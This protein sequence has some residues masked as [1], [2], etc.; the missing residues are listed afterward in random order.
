M[1]LNKP[2]FW[3]FKKANLVAYLLMPL[4]IFVRINNFILSFKVKKKNLKIKSIC[5]GN[6]YLGGTGKTPLTIK[7]YEI[8]KKL[9]LNVVVGKKFY[10]SQL[11]ERILLKKY[12]NTII[13]FD[14]KKILEKAI[15]RNFDSI[16]FDDGL[17]EKKL[18]YDLQIV[19]F[20]TQNFVG[21]NFLIPSGPLREKL[22]SLKKYDCV[23]LKDNNLS[24]QKIIKSIKKV[25]KKIKFFYT[26]FKIVNLNKF[27][28]S[29]KYLIYSGIG[30]PDSFKK[31]LKNNKFNIIKE[32]IF[33]D[34]FKYQKADIKNIKSYAKKLNA[35][36][37]TTEKDYVKISKLDQK[38]INFLKVETKIK[39]EKSFIKF[40]KT[41]IYD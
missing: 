3:D 40:V 16:I 9:G 23:F 32:M 34:H 37:I 10:S 2:K 18:S 29:D 36:I 33:P 35:K 28:K 39:N 25:N 1:K 21:N 24:N 4:T 30:N 6:I 19:C 12:T 26:Y 22:T 31:I 5:I 14:R 17:Q 8:I 13:D 7:I 27:K 11:D 15:R 38:N 20:D 41:K